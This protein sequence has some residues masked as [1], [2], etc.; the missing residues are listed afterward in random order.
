MSSLPVPLTGLVGRKAELVEASALL[1]GNRLLTLTGPG[2]A[3]KTRLALRLASAVAEDFPDGVWFVDFSPLSGGE[4]VLDQVATALAVRDPG[5][6]RTVAQAVAR[7]SGAKTR[8]SP[9]AGRGGRRGC[10][11]HPRS[12]SS[13]IVH[14]LRRIG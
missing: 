8:S 3:G 5:R 2:G 14:L 7:L 10:C 11:L 4:F 12:G 13:E 9:R 1:A 6:G